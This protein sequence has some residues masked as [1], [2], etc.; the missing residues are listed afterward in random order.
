VLLG[1]SVCA[2]LEAARAG[3]EAPE[4]S[5]KIAQSQPATSG[6]AAGR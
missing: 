6:A 1:G 4:D 2:E 5:R 3:A